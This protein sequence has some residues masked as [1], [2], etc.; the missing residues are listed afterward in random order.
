MPF[1]Q[2]PGSPKSPARAPVTLAI[3]RAPDLIHQR[4]EYTV[5][6]GFTALAQEVL[7]HS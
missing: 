6:G 5:S 1:S 3:N 4:G 2:L 7:N